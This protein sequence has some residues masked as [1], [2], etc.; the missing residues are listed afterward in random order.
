[1]A[2][3]VGQQE[4]LMILFTAFIEIFWEA[5]PGSSVPS[6]AWPCSVPDRDNRAHSQVLLFTCDALLSTGGADASTSVAARLTPRRQI[7]LGSVSRS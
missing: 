4:E 6:P 1:M 5:Y 3:I 7:R 2:N